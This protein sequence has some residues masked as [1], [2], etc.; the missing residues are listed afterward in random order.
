MLFRSGGVLA[1]VAR[2]S[3]ALE[4]S[5]GEVAALPW[6]YAIR[7]RGVMVGIDL[8]RPDGTPFDPSERIGHR[9]SMACRPRG[10]IVRPLGDTVVLNPP[11]SL[12]L[13]EAHALVAIVIR[14]LHDVLDR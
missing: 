11:L 12:L 4:A 9:V 10:A 2:L 1:H 6:V 13:D 8:R 14:A 5:L 7:H 3:R